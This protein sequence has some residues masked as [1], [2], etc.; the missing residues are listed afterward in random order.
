MEKNVFVLFHLSTGD[1][2]TMYALILYLK[3]I[4]ENVY[5]FCL[6]RNYE[7][8]TQLYELHPNIHICLCH[9]KNYNLCTVPRNTFYHYTSLVTNYDVIKSG[10]NDTNWIYT[11]NF[12]RSFYTDINYDYNM[13]YNFT[14]INRKHEKEITLLNKVKEIYGPKY[15][16]VHDHRNYIYNH[17][18]ARNNVIINSEMPIFHPNYNYYHDNTSNPFFSYWNSSFYLN[19]LFDYC[20]IIENAEEI[21]ITDSS[22]SCLCPYLDLSKVKKKVIYTNYDV[23]DYHNSFSDWIKLPPL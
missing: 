7:T 17:C 16:F 9:D 5:I 2:F 10:S 13:R 4:Y 12:W 15:I 21:H 11:S 3:T 19:N 6:H 8:I 18:C 14:S 23:I 20:S 22:F 1:N